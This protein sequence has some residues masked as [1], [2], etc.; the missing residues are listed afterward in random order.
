MKERIKNLVRQSIRK[1]GYDIVTTQ[2]LQSLLDSLAAGQDWVPKG[3]FYSPYP[4]LKEIRSRDADIFSTQKEIAGI[5]LREAAQMAWLEKFAE[6]YP[7]L[8]PYQEKKSAQFRYFYDN[9]NFSYS[10][11]IILYS[12]LRVI[13]P[14]RLIE[15][16]SGFSSALTLDTDELYLNR[17][18]ELTFID[19]Y[20]ERV[21]KLLKAEDKKHTRI[22]AKPVQSLDPAIF[23]ELQD[24]D[25]LFID[26][27][28]V[29]KVG[30]DVNYLYFE[31][32][33]R[34]NKGVYIHIHDI[35]F[36]F[37]YP[38]IWVYEGRVWNE[39]YLLRAFLLFNPCFQLE[40]FQNF[41]F[42][43]HLDFF[44]QHMPLCLKSGGDNI[45]LRKVG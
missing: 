31:V 9:E 42:I 38:S 10:D 27:T 44:R 36:P 2:Y 40:Y 7:E 14:K 16:G 35:F 12:M 45:W 41:M 6:V 24:G 34:L 25:I 13:Q 29:S 23:Q 1:F 32:L 43:K 15:V 8:P 4:D 19:P 17:S 3:H 28:H 18:V 22:I 11:A 21:Q 20:P 37:E 33:P 5:D 30:S 26:S 39:A